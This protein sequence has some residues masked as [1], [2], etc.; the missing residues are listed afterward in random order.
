MVIII[1]M[2]KIIPTLSYVILKMDT[3]HV[4]VVTCNND[5]YNFQ[6]VESFIMS[7]NLDAIP[8]FFRKL[9]SG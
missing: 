5:L 6:R 3:V 8:F 4:K 1:T 9:K 2:T 7:L